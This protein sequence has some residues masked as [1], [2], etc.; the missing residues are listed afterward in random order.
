MIPIFG[1][2]AI[3]VN[4]VIETII[5]ENDPD[6]RINQTFQRTEMTIITLF[7]WFKVL[8]FFR[9]FEATSYLIRI[10]VE[11]VKDMR[12]F[13]VVLFTTIIGFG[14]AFLILSEGNADA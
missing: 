8:Y 4:S 6:G 5:F 2:Y 12:H 13:L 11:V 9:I 3:L 1:I 14:N 10:I 7:M